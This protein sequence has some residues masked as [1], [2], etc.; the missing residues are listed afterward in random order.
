V[1]ELLALTSAACFGTS[2][3]LSGVFSRRADGLTVAC[4]AQAAGTVLSLLLVPFDGPAPGIPALAWG[5]LSGAG[6][7]VGVGFLFRAMGNG[8]LSVVVPLSDVG[9]VTLPVLVGLL[10]LGERPSASALAGIVLALPAIWLVSRADGARS[11]IAGMSGALVAGAG[12]AVQFLAMARIPAEA[13]LWPVVVSRVVSVVVLAA[14]PALTGV[15]VR[16]D[17]KALSGVAVSGS[18]GTLAIVLYLWAT[19]R[20]LM[21]VATV[22]SALYPAIP[23]VLG[24]V[25]LSERVNRRQVVGLLCAGAAIGLIAL[26]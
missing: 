10:F 5:A 7:A 16:L 1:G 17:R 6:T 19:Q 2:H 23:V 3:F 11:G 21:S 12:F 9:A 20:Q 25:L 15:P 26:K 8:P 22:L 18:L 4:Y 14:M 13:G 24:L